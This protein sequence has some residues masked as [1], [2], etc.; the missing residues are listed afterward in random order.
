MGE[1]AVPCFARPGDL[2]PLAER[3]PPAQRCTACRPLRSAGWQYGARYTWQLGH[4]SWRNAISGHFQNDSITQWSWQQQR[5]LQEVRQSSP[6][7]RARARRARWI[8]PRLAIRASSLTSVMRSPAPPSSLSSSSPSSPSCW[9][10]GA[11]VRR[12]HPHAPSLRAA[13]RLIEHDCA[14]MQTT[15]SYVV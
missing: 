7:P 11:P 13:H 2:D 1:S 4:T 14:G 3:H 10:S 9:T 15:V 5:W 12:M 6:L 8:L